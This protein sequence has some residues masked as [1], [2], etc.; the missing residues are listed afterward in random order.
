MVTLSRISSPVMELNRRIAEQPRA[1]PEKLEVTVRRIEQQFQEWLDSLP[2]NTQVTVPNLHRHQQDWP[3]G[4]FVA[5]HLTFQYYSI[6][7]YFNFLEQ[8][9]DGLPQSSLS[10]G[11][12]GKSPYIDHCKH[13]A[14][15]SGGILHLSRQLEG[16]LVSY[17][18]FSHIITVFS[19][20]LLHTL[21]LGD[22][23]EIRDAR[24]NLNANFEALVKLQQHWLATTAVVRKKESELRSFFGQ[25]CLGLLTL[26]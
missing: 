4:L 22:V 17:P 11:G 19:A 1:P 6:F 12:R 23:G 18:S 7:L 13:H 14:F 2:A 10:T 25:L 26:G 21:L 24:R 5:L 3:G 9:Q 20:V 16:C 15:S 8:G